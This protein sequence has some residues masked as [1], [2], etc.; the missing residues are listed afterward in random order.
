MHVPENMRM[1]GS[2]YWIG[3][4]S[5]IQFYPT[6]PLDFT[7]CNVLS[8]LACKIY[9]KGHGANSRFLVNNCFDLKK[10]YQNC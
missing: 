6:T 3:I 9:D 8:C 5:Q 2:C 4:N 10:F 1:P 7:E